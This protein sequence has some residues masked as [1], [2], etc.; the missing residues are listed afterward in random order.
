MTR[1]DARRF[2]SVF[3]AL[4]NIQENYEKEYADK[5]LGGDDDLALEGRGLL[6]RRTKKEIA[7]TIRPVVE[8]ARTL[9]PQQQGRAWKNA[10]AASHDVWQDLE[11]IGSVVP[12]LL[13]GSTLEWSEPRQKR[14]ENDR[15][16][17]ELPAD[18]GRRFESILYSLIRGSYFPFARCRKCE[19]VFARSRRS[20]IF[21]SRKCLV[22]D[23]LSRPDEKER[24][25][26]YMREYMR[27]RR[28][29]GAANV[30]QARNA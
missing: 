6:Y 2:L 7:D 25:R 18:P 30:R 19:L 16:V 11:M 4:S 13:E 1:A 29:R 23:R 12:C 3:A 10:A 26:N 14:I 24:R 15:L 27:I 5:G 20:Q 17:D 22:A 8:T 21:C 9:G 28:T